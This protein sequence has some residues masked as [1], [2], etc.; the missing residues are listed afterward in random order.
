MR[1]NKPDQTWLIN[2]GR[3]PSS[4]A[5]LPAAGGAGERMVVFGGVTPAFD[6][7]DVAVRG[8]G[9]C[10]LNNNTSG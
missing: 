6:L 5:V 10:G 2:L 4:A 7:A 9:V 1:V 3:G 8:G